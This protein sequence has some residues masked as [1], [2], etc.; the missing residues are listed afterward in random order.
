MLPLS[1]LRTA[2]NHPM[3]V[4]LKNGETYN[5]HLVSCDNWMNINLRE[6]ICTS[7]DGDKFWRMPECYIRGSTIKYLRIPDEVIDMVKEDTQAKTRGRGDMN[8]GRG[9]Q[10]M[11]TGRGSSRGAFGNRGRPAPLARGGG[12]QGRPQNKN[13][14]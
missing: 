3:L 7:R 11:R 10:N 4:E 12:N 8:K 14:K 1:L 13:K 2:Q 9:G 6:V 5:G